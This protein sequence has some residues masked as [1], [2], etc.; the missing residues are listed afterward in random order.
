MPTRETVTS[1]RTLDGLRLA[2]TPT[3]PDAVSGRAAPSAVAW[4]TEAGLDP[5]PAA[6]AAALDT[7]ST[8]A[9]DALFQFL[10]TLGLPD[11]P[12]EDDF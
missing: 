12:T 11:P 5:D 7:T 2:A 6:V 8:Y 10:A 4:A 9:E 3:T 1:L